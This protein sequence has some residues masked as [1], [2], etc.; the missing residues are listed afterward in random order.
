[1]GERF[2]LLETQWL[3]LLLRTLCKE[4]IYHQDQGLAWLD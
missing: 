2:D 4:Q 3:V 1:M